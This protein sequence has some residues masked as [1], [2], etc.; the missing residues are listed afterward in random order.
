[1]VGMVVD[2]GSLMKSML[3]KCL[4]FTL[5]FQI[6]LIFITKVCYGKK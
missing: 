6:V 2:K 5:S 1:M 3:N 4:F